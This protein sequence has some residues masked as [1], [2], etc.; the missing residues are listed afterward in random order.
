MDEKELIFNNLKKMALNKRTIMI[1]EEITSETALMVGEMLQLIKAKD[2]LDRVRD[3]NKYIIFEI[4]SGGGNCYSGYYICSLI[5]KY[6]N[7]YGYKIITRCCEICA[8]MASV[9]FVMGDEREMSEFSDVM[10]HQP[11]SGTQGI[12]NLTETEERAELLLRMWLRMKS[13]FLKRT[14]VE[15]FILE[16]IKRCKKDRYFNATECLNLGIATKIL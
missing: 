13:I 3:E 12:E 14:K 6:R 11:L 2:D 10:I 5:N 4:S 9:I 15:S 16:D 1:N 7:E 8:S